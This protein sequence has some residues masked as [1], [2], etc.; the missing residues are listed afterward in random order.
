M[1]LL[2]ATITVVHVVLFILGTFLSFAKPFV[3]TSLRVALTA[4][5]ITLSVVIYHKQEAL[6]GLIIKLRNKQQLF[7]EGGTSWRVESSNLN[8]VTCGLSLSLSLYL[9]LVQGIRVVSVLVV[10]QSM[11]HN[12]VASEHCPEATVVATTAVAGW[13]KNWHCLFLVSGVFSLTLVICVLS[14][15]P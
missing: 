14:Y 2:T 10:N 15:I 8:L 6:E 1:K 12:P 11:P 7:S 9:N 4:I 3:R 5:V 13:N